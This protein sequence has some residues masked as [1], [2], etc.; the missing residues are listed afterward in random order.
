METLLSLILFS[1][2]RPGF[3]LRTAT[4]SGGRALEDSYVKQ[5]QD[6]LLL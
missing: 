1:L 2:L 4:F 3:L 5:E 6:E